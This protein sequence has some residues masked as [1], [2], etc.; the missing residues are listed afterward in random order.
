MTRPFLPFF[1]PARPVFV[2][3]YGIQLA[4]KVWKKGDRFNWE[5]FGTPQEVIQ[6]LFFNDML[7]HNEALEEVAAKKVSIGDGLEE[8]S[9]DQLHL[10]VANINGK[11]K[12][13]TKNSTEFM[14]KKCATSKIKDKQVGLIRRWRISYGDLEN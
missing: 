2:K 5:F 14:Q 7:H 3:Q 13:K 8:Y 1:N 6:Q 12:A 11:V 9:V 10:L 4:G